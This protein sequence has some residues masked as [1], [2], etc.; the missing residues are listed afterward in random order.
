M[1]KEYCFSKVTITEKHSCREFNSPIFQNK[2]ETND[3]D[4]NL[5]H[6]CLWHFNISHFFHKSLR[7]QNKF[8][9]FLNQIKNKKLWFD[10]KWN[11]WC[12]NLGSID[13]IIRRIN[14]FSFISKFRFVF[15]FVFEIDIQQNYCEEKQFTIFLVL[16][17]DI[18][19]IQF[20]LTLDSCHPFYFLTFSKFLH[21]SLKPT[22]WT[23]CSNNVIILFNTSNLVKVHTWIN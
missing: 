13:E 3:P 23:S 10:V 11:F 15:Y 2:T 21:F 18:L 8:F 5:G 12:Q 4:S 17:F 14:Q 20:D 1:N 9:I 6:L 7:A 22:M 19:W 16:K